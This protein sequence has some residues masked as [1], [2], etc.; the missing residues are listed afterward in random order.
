MGWILIRQS[1]VGT[2][3]N[4]VERERKV[5][6][7]QS[8]RPQGFPKSALGD[9]DGGGGGAL[10]ARFTQQTKIRGT[11]KPIHIIKND[12]TKVRPQRE[13]QEVHPWCDKIFEKSQLTPSDL[14]TNFSKKLSYQEISCGTS[15]NSLERQTLDQYTKNCS[16]VLYTLHFL[17]PLN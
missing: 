6:H 13:L 16:L 7:Q 11:Q 3:I 17:S 4:N 14:V 5:G 12:F 1:R 9:T 15:Y 2:I 10:V 8:F